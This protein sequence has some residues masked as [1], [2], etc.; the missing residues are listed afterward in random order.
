M[1]NFKQAVKWLKEGKKVR[2][3]DKSW[4]KHFDYCKDGVE[5]FCGNIVEYYKDGNW[6]R[7]KTGIFWMLD[8]EATDWEIYYKYDELQ[9]IVKEKLKKIKND[10]KKS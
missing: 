8:F 3:N 6:L 2:R 4:L 7:E 5:G 1:S 9:Q 10:N